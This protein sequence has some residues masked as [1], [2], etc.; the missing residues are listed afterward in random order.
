MNG[1]PVSF[2]GASGG[3]GGASRGSSA[4]CS[5]QLDSAVPADGCFEGTIAFA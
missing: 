5:C 4:R 3:T 1:E 2:A